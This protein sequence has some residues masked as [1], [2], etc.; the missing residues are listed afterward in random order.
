MAAVTNNR[1]ALLTHGG[2]CIYCDMRI[3][4]NMV[5]TLEITDESTCICPCFVD[6]IVPEEWLA[7]LYEQLNGS[8]FEDTTTTPNSN[9]P[10]IIRI[11]IRTPRDVRKLIKYRGFGTTPQDAQIVAG[12]TPL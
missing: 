5:A 2:W 10:S 12:I 11:P 4:V 3:T 6:A 7:S 9:T 8:V 1:D